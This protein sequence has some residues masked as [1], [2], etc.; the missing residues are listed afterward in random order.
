M[1]V[2]LLLTNYVQHFVLP[3]SVMEANWVCA[4]VPTLHVPPSFLD[5]Q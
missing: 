1:Q 5:Y 2:A 4:R 3:H